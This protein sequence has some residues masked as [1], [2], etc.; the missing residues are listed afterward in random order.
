[1]NINTNAYILYIYKNIHLRAAT[2][3]AVI[4]NRRV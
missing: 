4:F 1:M 2:A 3:R